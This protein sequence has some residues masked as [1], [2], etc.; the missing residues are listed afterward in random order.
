MTHNQRLF[1]FLPVVLASGLF[2]KPDFESVSSRYVQRIES[3]TEV[4]NSTR[5][6]ILEEKE[7]LSRHIQNLNRE[8]IELQS[9]LLRLESDASNMQSRKVQRK[10]E[11][12]GQMENLNYSVMLAEDALSGLQTLLQAG[13]P[14]IYSQ[15]INQYQA[16]LNN[17]EIE[18]RLQF[19]RS[20]IDLILERLQRQVGGY[21]YNGQSLFQDDNRVYEG[22]YFFVGPMS[23]FFEESGQVGGLALER[24]QS[25]LPVT[26]P[27]DGV[28]KEKR[29]RLAL[30]EFAELPLDV[31]GGKALHLEEA[32]GTLREHVQ[33][34]GVVGY[35]ILFLGAFAFLTALLKAWDFR[36][37]AVDSPKVVKEVLNRV[38]T[39]S[40]S[41]QQEV[42]KGLRKS[43]R[44][45]FSIGARHA[46][47]PRELVEELMYAYI[48]L[49]RNHH[50]RRLPLLKVIAAAAPLLGLL[51]TVIGMMKTFTLITVFGTGNASKLSSGISEA[52]VT[53]ELGLVVAIPTLVIY[54]YLA[55]HTERKLLLLEQ[56][57]AD[58]LN[59]ITLRQS[60]QNPQP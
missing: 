44:E 29:D 19:A 14:M 46:E 8:V 5:Q 16:R 49:Q 21:Q 38:G 60:T 55:H 52:L 15:R 51:G 10:N 6:R 32:R 45:L 9:E 57:T 25:F 4:L 17:G 30:G 36:E 11:I 58:F 50:E 35:S 27:M 1:L 12:D 31:T 23:Y 18:T 47:K 22:D 20:A 40:I 41:N 7:P 2:A 24:Q 26:Y 34:G 54:G 13:E 59:T 48:L 53:T 39:Q 37:L 56:Y 33:K 3:A 43:A 28:T 42:W